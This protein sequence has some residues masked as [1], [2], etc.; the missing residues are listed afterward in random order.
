MYIQSEY[1]HMGDICTDELY[2]YVIYTL[3]LVDKHL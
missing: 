1:I 2:L 3:I